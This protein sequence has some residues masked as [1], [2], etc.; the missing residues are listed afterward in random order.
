MKL[1]Y[2]FIAAL[3]LISTQSFAQTGRDVHGTVQDSTKLTLPGST[4]K[5]LTDKDSLT[6]VTDAKGTFVFTG[7]KASQ[8]SLVVQSIGY[9]PIKRRMVLDNTNNPVF[10][11]PIILKASTTML[12]TVTISDVL[13]IKI[14]EDTVEFNAAAYKVRDGAPVEDVIRKI[15][16]ADVDKDGNIT[17]R[18]KSVTKV[19]VNGKDFFGGDLKTAT[20]NLPADAVQNVQMVNDYGDQANL[21]GIKTGEPETV[22]NINI[23]P[24]R[25]HGYFGQASAGAGQDAIPQIDGSKDG[26]RYIAQANLFN[27]ND[28]QQ[29]AVL[30]N[31]NNTNT[32]LFNF[33][34]PG[35]RSGG[36][37]GPP[38]SNNVTNGITT[39]RSIG[40]N[41]RDSWGKKI[42]VYGS[43]S[44]SDN[45]VNTI[46]STIQNNISLDNPSVN[47]QSSTQNDEK[48][49]H[50]FNFNLE[51]KP[52]TLNFLKVTPSYS[53]AGVNTTQ[54]GSNI[55]KNNAGIVSDY[56]FNSLTNSSAPNYGVNALYNHRFN[57]HGRNFSIN[58]GAGR[59]TSNTYQNPVYTYIQ[60]AANAPLDQF[61]NTNSHTDTLGTSIS[62]IEPLSKKSYV[63]VN[64]SY[65]HGYTTADKLTDTL[66]NDNT[67]NRYDLLSNNYNFT[68]IT[69]RFGLNYRFIDKKF[70]YVLG[71]TAQPTTLNG[72]SPTTGKST[73]VSTFNL[74][75]NAHYIYN[76]SRTQSISAN[77]SGSS[78]QP[79]YSELQP[80]TDFSNASYPITGNP[81]LKPE[82]NNSF[83]FRY[84]KFNFES[85]NVFFSNLSFTQTDNKIVSNTI[86]YPSGYTPN[87]KLSSTIETQYK[88]ASGYYTA[89]GF[90]VFAKPWEKRKYNLFFIGNASYSNNI[91]YITNV[92][93][94]TLDFT[95][96]KNIA[97]TIVLS[98]GIRFRVDITDVIDAELNTTYAINS[99]KNSITQT[100]INDNFRSWI[101]GVNGKNYVW[102]D[103]TWSYDYT[104]TLYY[105][106]KGA[107]NPNILNTYVERRFLKGNMATLGNGY[108]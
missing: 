51:Y 1:L 10:L 88:N 61:I 54:D 9:E 77:Y 91:S 12:N 48:K 2:F 27:F 85:G 101:L 73:S 56:T 49:N 90:Y 102:K 63:E 45:S 41:Y 33:G 94:T 98:Q 83:S 52:D 50:R 17:F 22:L 108:I 89:Q 97:K 106:Y 18:G 70:N 105:G 99:S 24:S 3:L 6:T 31:L 58:I 71:V 47:N 43:Y 76:F 65:H 26:T 14:K 4:I 67:V 13:P 36:G 62:Y 80:V 16:G 5:L 59:S 7:V 38:G 96:E 60:G 28:N 72:Y 46:S 93:P 34:G 74:S 19:R 69:N 25:N 86:T 104:K 84:N 79:T 82:Y 92:D 40:F 64:Y 23:K 95:T 8:F 68:F 103:W 55:L 78:N 21:T 32:N 107:T 75:P 29:I 20:Q 44:F 30:G 15:P 87:P 39:A 37:G 100:G 81:D 42:T 11:K 66:A 35:G 53:Y 57:G